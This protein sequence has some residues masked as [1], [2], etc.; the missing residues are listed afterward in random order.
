MDKAEVEPF[1]TSLVVERNV[2]AYT[3]EPGVV[4]AAGLHRELLG[5]FALVVRSD[6]STQAGSAR[7]GFALHGLAQLTSRKLGKRC[8]RSEQYHFLAIM[9]IHG[10]STDSSSPHRTSVR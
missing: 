5:G 8:V 4:G 10:T 6:A 3:P 1:L 2:T 9:A 7:V